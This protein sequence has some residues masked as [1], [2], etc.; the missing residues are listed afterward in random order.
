M[1]YNLTSN[2]NAKRVGLGP[3]LL[4]VNAFGGGTPSTSA[5]NDVGM[6]QSASFNVTRQK[7]ELI[8]GIPKTKVVQYVVQEDAVLNAVGLEWNLNSIY[9]SLGA[10]TG[11]FAN[12][13]DE[14]LKFGG[15]AALAQFGLQFI[16][17]LPAGGTVTLDMYNVQTGDNFTVNFDDNFHQIPHA[18]TALNAATAWVPSDV[19]GSKE[20]LFRIRVQI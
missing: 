12:G 20:Q 4:Y 11:T 7:V 19:L 5:S 18:Y 10:G 15:D 3:G 2:K 8:L 16:H 14:T 9:Q 13:N 6:V 17:Q 1:P